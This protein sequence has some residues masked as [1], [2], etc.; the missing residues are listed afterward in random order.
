MST[1]NMPIGRPTAG[2]CVVNFVPEKH[3]RHE[4][5]VQGC[6]LAHSHWMSSEDGVV[7]SVLSIEIRSAD[8][9]AGAKFDLWQASPVDLRRMSSALLSAADSLEAHQRQIGGAA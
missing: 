7:N 8:F 5:A 1:E 6:R 4:V 3:Y 9:M 2:S